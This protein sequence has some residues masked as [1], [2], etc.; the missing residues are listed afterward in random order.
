M[1]KTVL[2]FVTVSDLHIKGYDDE[3]CRRIGEMLEE[4]CSLAEKDPDHPALDALILNGDTANDGTEEQ[5]AAALNAVKTSLPRQ[6][7]LSV[8]IAR[9]H[10]CGRAK[11]RDGLALFRRLSGLETDFHKVIEGFHFIGVSVSDDIR[12]HYSDGQKAW[13]ANCVEYEPVY[14]ALR[15]LSAA[16]SSLRIRK[17]ASFV[18]LAAQHLKTK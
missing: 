13:L 14:F 12:V 3:N 7:D 9:Y 8:I 2:R 17:Y 15:H 6:T 18:F 1:A 4:V 5:F 16:S 11:D 10:D